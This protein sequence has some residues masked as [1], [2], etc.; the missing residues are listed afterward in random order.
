MKK[1]INSLSCKYDSISTT[2]CQVYNPVLS[3]SKGMVLCKKCLDN[4]VTLA[5]GVKMKYKEFA[6]L[7]TMS[8]KNKAETLSKLK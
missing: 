4:K 7:T 5:G 1:I 3:K 8:T 2:L 6:Q